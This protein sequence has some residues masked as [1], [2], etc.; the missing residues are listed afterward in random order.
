M[1]HPSPSALLSEFPASTPAEW[2]KAAEALLK[3]APFE[4]RLVTSTIEGITTQPIYGPGDVA[5]D[6]DQVPGADRFVRG[7]RAAGY[8]G[9]GWAISQELPGA[10]ADAFN[11]VALS[12]LQNGQTEL[13]IVLDAASGSGLDPDLATPAQVGARGLS[14]APERT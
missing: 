5:A 3:G 1:S 10:T 8:L 9:G 14:L 4:K 2:R 7:R 11:A 6:L 12:A 13:N